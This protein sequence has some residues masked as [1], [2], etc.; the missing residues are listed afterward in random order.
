MLTQLNDLKEYDPTNTN[1]MNSIKETI[2]SEKLYKNRGIVIKAFENGVFPFKNGFQK[3]ES[4]MADKTPEWVN[5][6][7]KRFDKMENKV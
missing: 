5:V 7:K 3:T 2:N 6:I 4:D 1:K